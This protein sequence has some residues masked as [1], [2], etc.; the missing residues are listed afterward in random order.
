MG[1]RFRRTVRLF[2]G[3]RL[4]FSRSGVSASVGV[5]GATMTLG[6]RGTYANVGI[7]GSGL[8]YRTRLS[9]VASASVGPRSNT[10]NTW[11]ETESASVPRKGLQPYLI[12]LAVLTI[13]LA[14]AGL[15][16]N[17]PGGE[18]LASSPS[19]T[20]AR[21]SQS[22]EGPASA[23][24]RSSARPQKRPSHHRHRNRAKLHRHASMKARQAR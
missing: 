12:L 1:F 23:K 9:G 3:V 24:L 4:N 22:A 13:G 19:T 11:T 17:Q 18:K 10:D 7:P 5:R 21:L 8:S 2:P 15:K 6:R 14:F 16:Q 20:T